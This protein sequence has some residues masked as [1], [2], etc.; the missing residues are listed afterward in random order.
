[1]L[2]AAGVA[3]TTGSSEAAHLI[4]RLW[5]HAPEADDELHA[6]AVA[7]AAR[8]LALRS[9]AARAEVAG[10]LAAP[11]RVALAHIWLADQSDRDEQAALVEVAVRL[12]L[13]D[14]AVPALDSWA[15]ARLSGWSLA[16]SMESR[17]RR[18]ARLTAGLKEMAG[19]R[20]RRPW[21]REGR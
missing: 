4:Q 6:E 5:N 21:S 16:L 2:L 11:V 19:G 14:A 18:D 1:M 15:R 8:V 9:P 17:F 13:A 20:R 7:T 3:E 12:H 10:A